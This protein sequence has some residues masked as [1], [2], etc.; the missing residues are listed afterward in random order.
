MNDA[1]TLFGKIQKLDGDFSAQ[2]TKAQAAEAALVSVYTE[3]GNP[4]PLLEK[5]ATETA[6]L[7]GQ[8]AALT[9]LDGQLF[10]LQKSEYDAEVA[11]LQ[12]AFD[13]GIAAL[14]GDLDK[15]FRDTVKPL[16][17]GYGIDLDELADEVA[18]TLK[19]KAWAELRQVMTAAVRV[20]PVPK[21][22]ATR[23]LT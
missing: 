23:T 17:H 20:L 18:S 7:N 11:R 5:L 10:Q 8:K 15:L 12:K 9:V 19:D 21:T 2:K 22:P 16:V 14:E 3:G 4:A 1:K 6:A 13:R